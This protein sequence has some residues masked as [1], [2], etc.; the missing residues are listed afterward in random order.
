MKVLRF[1][2]TDMREALRRVRDELGAEAMIVGNQRV[3]EG[4]EVTAALDYEAAMAAW[5]A[6]RVTRQPAAPIRSDDE[7]EA[8][9]AML[10]GT[11]PVAA[12]K[13]PAPVVPTV[14]SVNADAERELRL[15]RDEVSALKQLLSAQLQP[16]AEP[17]IAAVADNNASRPAR[18][19]VGAAED[20]LLAKLEAWGLS[21]A[22]AQQ[23]AGS[24]PPQADADRRWRLALRRIA[25]GVAVSSL[26]DASGVLLMIGAPGS[27]VT[28]A[29]AK[30]AQQR[31][32]A[33]RGG[34]VGLLGVAAPGQ[35]ADHRLAR[36]GELL[37][38]P[39]TQLAA[40]EPLDQA[41]ARLG[42]CQLVLVDC[43]VADRAGRQ[44]LQGLLKGCHYRTQVCQVFDS[45]E[46]VSEL[47]KKRDDFRAF[48]P[49][50]SMLSKV[51]IA[52]VGGRIID[53]LLTMGLPVAG[54]VDS[55]RLGRPLQ[56]AEPRTWISQAHQDEGTR[57]AA[58]ASEP[59]LV[60]EESPRGRWRERRAALRRDLMSS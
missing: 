57:S 53:W 30:L 35:A 6:E 11:L 8:V 17:V 39:V 10:T 14:I 27:G 36:L 4:I 46:S 19:R 3:P 18:R 34:Q 42:R 5:Q 52:P 51:D 31:L 25:D 26:A 56:A 22:N 23:V 13:L 41:L 15:L 1:R 45:A 54:V 24:V 29:L 2:A 55:S 60:V 32:Q 20:G 28:T 50:A 47:A 21:A 43:R 40:G 7:L 37:S 48:T 44:W 38:V 12:V 9:K 33:G 49:K 59:T 58:K 16:V